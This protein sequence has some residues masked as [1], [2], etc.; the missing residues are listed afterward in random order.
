VQRPA[1]IKLDANAQVANRYAVVTFAEIW[2]DQVVLHLLIERADLEAGFPAEF[3]FEL[4]DDLATSYRMGRAGSALRDDHWAVSVGFRPAVPS[5]A[6][7]LVLR[8]AMLGLSAEVPIGE[9]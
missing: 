1:L 3:D 8:S 7:K 5:S 2:N 9:R 4:E 6:S